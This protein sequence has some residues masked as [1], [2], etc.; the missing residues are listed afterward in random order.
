[1]VRLDLALKI[2]RDPNPDFTW[3][4]TKTAVWG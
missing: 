1:M 2:L 3:E 4:G